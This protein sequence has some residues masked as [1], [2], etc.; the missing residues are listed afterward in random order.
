MNTTYSKMPITHYNH[1]YYLSITPPKINMSPKKG[2]KGKDRLPTIIFD[3]LCEF[4][5]VVTH[6][7]DGR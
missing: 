1:T 7:H 6:Q 4:S 5:G 3:E 2:L